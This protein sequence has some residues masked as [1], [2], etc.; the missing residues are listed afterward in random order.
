MSANFLDRPRSKYNHLLHKSEI[1]SMWLY[2]QVVSE[3]RGHVSSRRGSHVAVYSATKTQH[4]RDTKTQNISSA[5]TRFRGCLGGFLCSFFS[6][7]E[8]NWIFFF[9]LS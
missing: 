2:V 5:F 3:T 7:F 9:A 1:S 6:I 4:M 8:F